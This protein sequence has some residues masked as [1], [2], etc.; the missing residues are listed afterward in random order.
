M[1]KSLNLQPKKGQRLSSKLF[2]CSIHEFQFNLPSC[3]VPITVRNVS[4]APD[5]KHSREEPPT[6][7]IDDY[8]RELI[9]QKIKFRVKQ[10]MW[11]LIRKNFEKPLADP[12]PP[13]D[14]KT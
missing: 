9:K 10:E 4:T 8:R 6:Q 3:S 5:R 1:G 11:N 12:A 7:P 13:Q 2:A 14:A